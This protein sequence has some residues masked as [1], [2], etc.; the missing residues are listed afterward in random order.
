MPSLLTMAVSTASESARIGQPGQV[1][2]A[3]TCAL[4]LTIWLA[5]HCV[6]VRMLCT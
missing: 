5:P 4:L 6:L 2:K 3:V 1:G